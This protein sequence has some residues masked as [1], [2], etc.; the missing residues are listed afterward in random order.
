LTTTRWRTSPHSP[1][2]ANLRNFYAEN[3][4]NQ[5]HHDAGNF[6]QG[7]LPFT[8]TNNPVQDIKPLATLKGMERLG[9]AKRRSGRLGAARRNDG[10]DLFCF[11][12]ETRSPDL[13]VLVGM[14]KKDFEGQKRFATFLADLPEGEP[15][16]GCRQGSGGRIEEVCAGDCSWSNATHTTHETYKSHL[17]SLRS[18]STVE[19]WPIGVVTS[20]D[21]GLGVKLEV[22]FT[23][24]CA[25]DSNSL[26]PIKQPVRRQAPTHS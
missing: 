6:D 26:R 9:S 17:P 11:W 24:W 4:Q 19:K 13:S 22:C 16:F 21:A 23:N 7:L 15:A 3:N 25:N 14:A 18:F 2:L 1:K 8:S 10:T 20:V 5:G 12:K